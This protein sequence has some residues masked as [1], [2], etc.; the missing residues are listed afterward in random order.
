MEKK[1]TVQL[2]GK[3]SLSKQY[4]FNDNSTILFAT[5]GDLASGHFNVQVVPKTLHNVRL[6]H[7]W[8]VLFLQH[9]PVYCQYQVIGPS[10]LQT[11]LLF[12]CL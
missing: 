2:W 12:I 7:N 11:F 4:G 6:L 9:F 3:V 5:M 8:M 1:S 10:V